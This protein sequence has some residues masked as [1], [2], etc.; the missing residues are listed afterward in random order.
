MILNPFK[1]KEPERKCF[2]CMMP[3][4][5]NPSEIRYKYQDG[6]GVVHI[7]GVCSEE[8]NKDTIDKDR[9]DDISI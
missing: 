8:F 2:I 6:E 1:K 3:I 5:S 9:E 4:G 7:C